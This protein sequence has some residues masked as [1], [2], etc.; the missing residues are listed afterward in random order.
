MLYPFFDAIY[1][2]ILSYGILSYLDAATIV[3]MIYFIMVIGFL[4]VV[5]HLYNTLFFCP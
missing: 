3:T 5:T 4:D 1:F 2:F